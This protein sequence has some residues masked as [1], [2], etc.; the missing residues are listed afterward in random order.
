M[1]RRALDTM[2]EADWTDRLAVALS[3]A[4]IV[5]MVLA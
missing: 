3:V 2:A 5:L 1:M 4:V